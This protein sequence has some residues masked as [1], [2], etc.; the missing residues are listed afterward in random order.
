MVTDLST[1]HSLRDT[2]LSHT[3]ALIAYLLESNI[4]ASYRLLA[5]S[6]VD[7]PRAI[8]SAGPQTSLGWG[9]IR[10]A[11]ELAPQRAQH[12]PKVRRSSL[13]LQRRSPSADTEE[14]SILFSTE[15][16]LVQRD[17]AKKSSLT[18][19]SIFESAIVEDGEDEEYG[20]SLLRVGSGLDVRLKKGWR[21]ASPSGASGSEE[22][23]EEESADVLVAKEVERRGA[24]QG[25]VHVL[26][27]LLNVSLI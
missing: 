8:P 11:P 4:P 1:L 22:E 5:R 17:A 16:I 19:G 10:L 27:T 24:R 13:V 2:T 9:C 15:R 18:G 12:K 14:A 21:E 3:H 25:W 20:V 6:T 7:S 26:L 23:A